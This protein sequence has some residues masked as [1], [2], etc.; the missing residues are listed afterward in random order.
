MRWVDPDGRV[1]E[2]PQGQQPHSDFLGPER[3]ETFAQF[4]ERKYGKFKPIVSSTLPTGLKKEAYKIAREKMD[5][6]D[7]LTLR[8]NWEEGF[9]VRSVNGKLEGRVWTDNDSGDVCWRNGEGTL[10]VWGH[11]HVPPWRF[12][13]LTPSG[14]ESTRGGDRS[15]AL[16]LPTVFHLLTQPGGKRW[17][18]T[19]GTKV[20][21][22]SK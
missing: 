7:A 9:D 15:I 10:I 12:G 17:D 20:I 18:F 5:A 14:F 11:S 2:E 22:N 4:C 3:G 13:E 16:S 19:G 8:T 6:A 1:A 21:F